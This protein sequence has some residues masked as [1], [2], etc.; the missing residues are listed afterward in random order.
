MKPEIICVKLFR[1]S[2]WLHTHNMHVSAKLVKAVII[3]VFGMHID[4]RAKIGEGFQIHNGFGLVIGREVKAG[5]NFNVS[6][7]VT[8]GGN[9]G[10]RKEGRIYPVIGSNVWIMAGA[11]VAGPITVGSNVL[12]GANSVV[13]RDVPDNVVVAGTPARIIREIEDFDIELL[14]KYRNYL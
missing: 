7:G 4:F 2:Q 9:W 1:L 6:Q 14:N 5:T 8:V 3:F 13:I 10:K 11:V 12:I